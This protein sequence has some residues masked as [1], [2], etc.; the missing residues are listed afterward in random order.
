MRKRKRSQPK[1]GP[2]PSPDLPDEM[3]LPPLPKAEDFENPKELF[4]E[5]LTAYHQGQVMTFINVAKKLSEAKK[6]LSEEDFDRVWRMAMRGKPSMNR[7][8]VL[9]IGEILFGLNK[10]IYRSLPLHWAI[11]H[12]LAQLKPATLEALAK[13]GKIFPRMKRADA[14]QLVFEDRGG[15]S[16]AE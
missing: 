11:L 16:L 8:K 3:V 1:A 4:L 10:A 15:D 14:E 6:E 5:A 12:C 13:S 9:F 2:G 7:E